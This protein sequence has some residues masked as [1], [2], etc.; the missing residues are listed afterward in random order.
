M[1]GSGFRTITVTGQLYER[2][3]RQARESGSSVSGYVS[4][5]LLATFKV[6]DSLS[7]CATPF[8]LI[9]MGR[10][11]VVMRDKKKDKVVGVK[12]KPADGG[13]VRLYCELDGTDYCPHTAFAAALPQVRNAIRRR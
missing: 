11:D 5:I 10:N 3:K 8:D 12:A 6:E 13:K 1:A 9:S 4:E 7:G 2:V